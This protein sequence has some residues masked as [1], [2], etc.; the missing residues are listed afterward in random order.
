MSVLCYFQCN[1]SS[2]RQELTMRP[3]SSLRL[4]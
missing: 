3:N 2:D 4:S 1:F